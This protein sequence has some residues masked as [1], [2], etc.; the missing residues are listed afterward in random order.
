MV[1]WAVSLAL[2]FSLV[3]QPM[4]SYDQ[5][6]WDKKLSIFYSAA[7]RKKNVLLRSCLQQLHSAFQEMSCSS[8]IKS[9]VTA[10]EY[11]QQ[12]QVLNKLKG[13][14]EK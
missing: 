3:R 13:T 1:A 2:A 12:A 4:T 11:C 9:S 5:G 10:A 6:A 7:N 8:S 14:E